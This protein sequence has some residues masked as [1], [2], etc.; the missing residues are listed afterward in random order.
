MRG[1]KASKKDEVVDSV[2][3][4]ASLASERRLRC[5]IELSSDYY[6]EQDENHRF[7]L[8]L[9]R[10][11]SQP[12]NDPQLFLGKTS[13]ELG[14]IP[15]DGHGTW[16]E[17]KALREARR[18]FEDFVVC[19]SNAAIGERYLSISGQ[20]VFGARGE[21]QGYS[22]IAKDVTKERRHQRLLKLER[23]VMGALGDA[24]DTT[25]ALPAAIRAICESER[26]EA[27]QYWSLDEK[28]NVMRFHSG[29]SIA[30]TTIERVTA[31]AKDL[32]LARGDGLV[33]AVW[34]TQQPLWVPDLGKE[35][36][37]LRKGIE[38][39][40]GWKSALLF[41][42]FSRGEIIGVLDFNARHIPKPDERLLQVVHVLG[43][44]IGNFYQ[45]A[46]S[47]QELRESK[48]R[49]SSTIEI[50]AI[51]ISHVALDGTFI[52][53][54]RQLCEMLGYTKEELLGLTVKEISHPD[55][56]RV[57]DENRAK[58]RAGLIDSFNVEKR[59]LHKNGSTVWVRIAVAMMRGANREPL[60]D[61]SVVEDISERKRVED[62]VQY[63]ATHDEMTRLPNR[64][65]FTELLNHSVDVAK[66]Y[67]RRF[68][69]LFIDLDR[70]KIV[71]DSLGHEAGDTLLKEMSSRLREC[72]RA[73][74]VVA[75]LG[76]DE[77]V[78]LIDN[79]DE[80]SQAAR[81]ARSILSTVIKP[82]E[83]MGQE[84]RVTA[85]IGIATYPA[86]A[87]DAQSLMKNADMAMY[88]A[89]DEGKNNYQFYSKE[90]RAMSIE[91][92]ALETNLRHALERNE[93]VLHYQA[94]VNSKTG[95]I[96]GV[97]ALLRWWNHDLGAVSPA[98]FIPVAEDTGLIV[99]I[100]RWVLETACA[101]S[102]A[103]QRQGLPAICMAVN[104]SPR[105]FKDAALLDDIKEVIDKTGIPAHLLE[106]E[107]TEGM[108]MSNVDQAIEKLRAI[109]GMGVRLAIDDFG[110][111]Y[112]SLAQLKRFPIDTLKVDRS[113]IRDIP[114]NAEDKAIAEAIIAMGRTLGVTVVAEGV[115]TAE[116]QTFLSGRGCE[117]MQGYYFG[118]P[119]H[120]DQFAR[121]LRGA[122]PSASA[123]GRG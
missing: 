32:A 5:V 36:R 74:D 54:N 11:A 112:S 113:F 3:K 8:L 39:Q 52:H 25:D 13:W 121:L 116:Q 18:P 10:N 84:C 47:L 111:G 91:R 117:G 118:K 86:D 120:A 50:A 68:G 15:A 23:V 24:A 90:A 75:R 64:A 12:E 97:E 123:G 46:I 29:W 105:Q 2:V 55:D 70:F 107:I 51:G 78:V 106:L 41:P 114:E 16:E 81:V 34:Q 38:K 65:M 20:P 79:I 19:R 61:I 83:I 119:S 17:H 62:R 85:S 27:G 44:Q 103:W 72:L 14:G 4:Q 115:E 99:P 37:V 108:I 53:V 1:A 40:T 93:L 7:T 98:Q 31:Q 59:Y 63:L 96:N 48:E 22:G 42:V 28:S 102:M 77:F 21:F 109:K 58:L 33:G 104:L 95:E 71:N 49:Y 43:T 60:Y 122:V 100:G 76:G 30:D 56:A 88:V 89:K 82:V 69:V 110:T 9:H 80:P 66:R 87:D 94:K 67:D 92:L 101:Q 45:R 6:W 26:W 57:T 35:S 73:S